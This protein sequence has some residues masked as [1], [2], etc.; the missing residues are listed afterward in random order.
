[1]PACPLTTNPPLRRHPLRSPRAA[2]LRLRHQRRL[3]HPEE[4]HPIARHL[5]HQSPCLANQY[6]LGP[7]TWKMDSSL[8]KSSS[9]PQGHRKR[10]RQSPRRLRHLHRPRP[11][12]PQS[13]G[14][15][16]I[17]RT[18]TEAWGAEIHG[19]MPFQSGEVFPALKIAGF[20]ISLYE[21]WAFYHARMV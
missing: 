21:T 3:Y 2:R 5:R 9:S 11:A 13:A 19:S 20:Q 15:S 16:G 10:P 14:T 8:R 17:A 7:F 12:R 6:M 4:W 18:P 1:M